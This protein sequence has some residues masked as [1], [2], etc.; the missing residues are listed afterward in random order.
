MEQL[1]S[2]GDTDL[3]ERI[4]ARDAKAF[5][6]LYDRHSRAAYA[7]AWRILGDPTGVEDVVQEAFLE[8]WRGSDAYHQDHGQVR[9][10][11]LAIVHHRAIDYVR[12]RSYREDRQ[13]TLEDVGVTTDSA[14]TWEQAR[15]S[16]EGQQVREALARLPRDQQDSIL[17][18][19][20]DGYT[21]AE[22]A[23]TLGIPLGTVKG[24]LRIG[25]QKMR[26][27]LHR[28]GLEA[29]G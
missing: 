26:G 15:Q 13:Q 5:A 12:R 4:R 22:I 9:T 7:L 16:V 2:A 29:P 25:L 6:L 27:Y 1:A 3:L 23:R 28:Q 17:L 24:R 8:V 19:Y 10:W 14:D 21:H 11:L 20:F 18:A